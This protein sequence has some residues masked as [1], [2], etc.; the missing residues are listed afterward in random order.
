V[1]N[2]QR[3]TLIAFLAYFVLSGMLAPIGIVS[4]PMS[5]VYGLPVSQITSQFSWLT[6][7]N[8]MGAV[9]A[10]IVFDWVDLRRMLVTIY[11]VLAVGLLSLAHV[12]SL[13]YARVVLGVAGVCGGIGLAGAALIIARTYEGE[14][15]A[16]LLVITDGC[17][18]VAGFVCGSLASF[19]VARKLGWTSTYQCIGV[20]A[21]LI[22]AL[23]FASD[24]PATR[25][26]GPIHRVA[27]SWPVPVWLCV[28]ALFL[29]SLGQYS[30]VFWLPNYASLQLGASPDVGGSIVGKFWLGMFLGQ[31]FVAWWVLRVGLR[32]L[33]A[34]A[35]ITTAFG[36]IPLWGVFDPSFLPTLALLWGIGNLSMM[37]SLLS[38]G[39][40]FVSVPD[41]R[42][43]SGL[44]LGAT[45][46]TALSPAVSSLLVEWTDIRV[47]LICS[48]ACH[49]VML[50]LVFLSRRMR[51]GTAVAANDGDAL[52]T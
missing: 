15:R 33:V 5:E 17:F 48:T 30:M 2:R 11:G 27:V 43:V 31:M 21:A 46:G 47:V 13:A 51:Q 8:F 36:S 35:A 42:L 7:G 44:L 37:K 1:N 23:S 12:D 34:I 39:T 45:L 6:G 24:L 41:A 32:R 14:R 22:A 49:V 9:M 29:Y 4:G 19:F 10:L 3:I 50:L 38:F 52:V 20:L 40:T 18:S 16:S 25:R 26:K 28:S